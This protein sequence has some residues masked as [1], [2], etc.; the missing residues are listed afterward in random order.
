MIEFTDEDLKRFNFFCG[1]YVAATIEDIRRQVFDRVKSER[2]EEGGVIAE[3]PSDIRLIFGVELT[4]KQSRKKICEF[5]GTDSLFVIIEKQKTPEEIKIIEFAKEIRKKIESQNEGQNE[6]HAYHCC[7][8]LESIA[9]VIHRSMGG[10]KKMAEIID[11]QLFKYRPYFE[12]NKVL[13]GEAL[14]YL[15]SFTKVI[16]LQQS[17]VELM[18]IR[19][20][21]EQASQSQ[22]ISQS[23]DKPKCLVM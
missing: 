16:S 3:S 22:Y 8:C 4:P 19:R 14:K 5:M 9:R 20:A 17:T 18:V 11:E 21:H 23:A 6:A 15:R 7:L 1:N 2:Y 13:F 12:R 10:P